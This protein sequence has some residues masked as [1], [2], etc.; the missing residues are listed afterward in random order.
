MATASTIAAPPQSLW[1]LAAPVVVWLGHFVASYATTAAAC[2]RWAA[3][4][5][6]LS[7]PALVAAYTVV[8]LLAL[9]ACLIAGARD[10]PVLEPARALD[11]D[12]PAVR[13]QFV[14]TTNALLVLA[15]A[16][17]VVFVGAATLMVPTCH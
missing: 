16:I 17:A 5:D 13:G 10:W 15:G 7:A 11:D 12:L 1:R 8:A 14:A 2:G 9:S 6:G 3:R 4:F